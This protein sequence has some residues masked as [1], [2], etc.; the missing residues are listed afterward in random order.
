MDSKNIKILFVSST[1]NFQKFNRPFMRLCKEKGWIVDYVSAGEEKILD[2]DRDYKIDL[3]RSPF[4]FKNLKAISQM[5]KILNENE[6]DIIHCHTPMGSVVARIAGKKFRKKGLKIIYT[7]HGF[8][9]YKDAPLLNWI[10]YYPVEK[11]LARYTDAIITINNEDYKRAVKKFGKYTKVYFM[12]GIGVDLNRFSPLSSQKIST[13]RKELGYSDNNFIITV[14][15]E[16]N[17]NKN[18]IFLIEQLP[19]LKR[20][21]SN[22]KVLFAGNETLPSA[23]QKVD[24]LNLN[25][26]CEFLGYRNDI[27]LIEKI[28]NICFSASKREGLPI[29]V[30]E[31]MACGKVCICS[32]NRG[33]NSLLNDGVNG[34]L[35]DLNN[36]TQMKEDI[37]FVY[38]CKEE[39]RNL[40]KKA[41]E[42]SIQYDIN[43]AIETIRNIY[44]EIIRGGV[45]E[46]LFFINLQSFACNKSKEF[47]K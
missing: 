22:L 16:C 21:I 34:L 5:K 7:A 28:S 40:A 41:L 19:E 23:R 17:K 12:N 2:C 20:K 31:G 1:A 9:F 30:I 36:P 4:S 10:L 8:H 14:V 18:Q 37:L 46:Y 29:N 35:F 26:V 13:I 47:W 15:A 44:D 45:I 3:S 25:D 27:D 11:I 42:D 39:A 38:N 32:K 6:Y 24:E 43:F 33:H